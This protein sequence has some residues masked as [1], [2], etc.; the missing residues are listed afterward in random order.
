MQLQR[1]YLFSNWYLQTCF[2]FVWAQRAAVTTRPGRALPPD[3]SSPA[4]ASVRDGTRWRRSPV[5]TLSWTLAPTGRAYAICRCC[6]TLRLTVYAMHSPTGTS[7]WLHEHAAV[8]R[9]LCTSSAAAAAALPTGHYRVSGTVPILGRVHTGL[10]WQA[11]NIRFSSHWDWRTSEDF[12]QSSLHSTSARRIGEEFGCQTWMWSYQIQ[13]RFVGSVYDEVTGG[14]WLWTPST[15]SVGSV[16]LSDRL[17]AWRFCLTSPALFTSPARG[18]KM[19]TV[20]VLED[21][22]LPIFRTVRGV[23]RSVLFRK[24]V[25]ITD[26]TESSQRTDS[27]EC[28]SITHSSERS[29]LTKPTECTLITDSTECTSIT[30]STECTSITDSTQCASASSE[31]G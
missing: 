27:T 28:H 15:Q 25:S 5:Y 23:V 16:V 4:A 13:P 12:F 11:A 8:S 10:S 30:D 18:A 26:S 2:C 1:N 14:I 31:K 7:C 9:R 19:P 21:H 3:C 24:S 17:S 22:I 6:Y 20:T 29:S